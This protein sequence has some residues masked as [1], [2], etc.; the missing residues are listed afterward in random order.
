MLIFRD[1]VACNRETGRDAVE[2]H[3]DALR[4]QIE[5]CIPVPD[6]GDLEIFAREQGIAR[7]RDRE[8][9]ELRGGRS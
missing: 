8:V 3:G 4:R 6:G 2:A 5:T 7:Y 1:R 9:G